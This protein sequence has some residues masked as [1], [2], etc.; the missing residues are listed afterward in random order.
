MVTACPM[1][2]KLLLFAGLLTGVVLG[3]YFFWHADESPGRIDPSNTSLVKLGAEIYAARC[4]SCH[5]TKLEGQR[6]NWREKFPDGRWPAPPHDASGHTWHHSDRILFEITK[7]GY[8]RQ[9]G[10]APGSTM[11]G[12]DS[13]LS[14]WEIWA[15]LSYIKSRWPTE[16]QKRHDSINRRFQLRQ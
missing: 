10:R 4:A 13:V 5:G 16:I 11:P 7:H 1:K 15:A 9:A 14:D 8:L 3:T 6:P 2:P 12:F